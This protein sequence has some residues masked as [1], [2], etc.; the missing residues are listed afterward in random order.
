MPYKFTSSRI[1]SG[2][3][4]FPITIIIDNHNFCYYKGNLVGGTRMT[5][6]KSSIASIRLNKGLLFSDLII[7]TRG[8]C[9]LYLN[10]FSHS[11]GHSIHNLLKG[12][13]LNL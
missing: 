1:T 8:G 9:I 4:V 13:E 6:P 5:I 10:G 11:D 12:D 3:A 7:E 2:N